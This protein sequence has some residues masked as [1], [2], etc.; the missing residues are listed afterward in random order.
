MLGAADGNRMTSRALRAG[1]AADAGR[2]GP[3]VDDRDWERLLVGLERDGLIHRSGG[4]I[5]LGTATIGA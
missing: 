3:A 5:G 2:I 4:F 1:L